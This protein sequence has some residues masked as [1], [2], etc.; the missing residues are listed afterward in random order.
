[1][2][3]VVKTI[4]RKDAILQGLSKYF[5]G[6][7]CKH[8]HIAERLV[9]N[10]TCYDCTKLRVAKWQQKNP[11]R[12]KKNHAAWVERNPGVANKR[13]KQWY[14]QNLTRHNQQMKRYFEENPH[15]RAKLSSIQRAAQNHRTPKWL[16]DDD[17]WMMDEIYRLAGLRTA[18]TGVA[19]HVDHVI[20]LRG[21]LVSGLHVPSNLRVVEWKENLTKGNRYAVS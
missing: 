14:R 5:T 21:K 3:G 13:R 17:F 15:L 18:S 2:D 8:G 4:S 1:M 9:V 20:P 10:G 19:W 16:T 12:V 11:E 7:P 6:K